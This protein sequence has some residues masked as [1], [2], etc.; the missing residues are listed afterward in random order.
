VAEDR[1][2][3]LQRLRPGVER[4]GVK[5]CP[6]CA[7]ELPDEAT[8][9]SHCHK[10]PAVAPA[11]AAQRP[12]EG[13]PPAPG[14]VWEP[15]S[16]PRISGGVPAQY[17]GLEPEAARNGSL[18][19]PWKV[20]VSLALAFGWGLIP[21]SVTPQLGTA[22]LLLQPVGYVAGL[23]FGNMG[24]VEARARTGSGRSSRSSRSR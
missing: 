22:G 17:K 16:D 5:V 7:E 13:L 4:S 21:I 9:C 15:N 24:R 8:V 12:S 14:D 19:I 18:G 10:D 23:I 2:R 3:G 11:R 1:L 20:W 6:H